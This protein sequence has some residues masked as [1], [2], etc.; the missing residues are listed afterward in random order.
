MIAEF[1]P[2]IA[3]HFLGMVRE[4]LV[5]KREGHFEEGSGEGGGGRGC[6]H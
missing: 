3:A 6:C 5:I 1:R 2:L 4:L